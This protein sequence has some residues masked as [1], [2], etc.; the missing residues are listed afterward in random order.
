M[1]NLQIRLFE[2]MTHK[3]MSMADIEKSTGL[4]K[5]TL[6]SILSGMSKNP[7][8]NTLKSIAKALDV[9][10]E[11]I[12]SDKKLDFETL[13]KD[14]MRIFSEVTKETIDTIIEKDIIFTL[15]KI[16]ALI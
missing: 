14:Q 10:L 15:D 7:T 16:C 13:T 1:V 9:S 3:N 2:L 11:D 8:A 4:N 5:N 12:L 6:N